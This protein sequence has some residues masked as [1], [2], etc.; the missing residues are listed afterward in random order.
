M[1]EAST[2][3]MKGETDSCAE[4]RRLLCPPSIMGRSSRQK[5]TRETGL[6]QY[7]SQMGFRNTCR[8]SCPMTVGH[9]LLTCTGDIL[10]ITCQVTKQVSK[11]N[12]TDVIPSIFN[13]HRGVKPEIHSSRKIHTYAETKQPSCAHSGS[14]RNKTGNL[15]I[16]QDDQNENIPKLLGCRKSNPK[17][18]V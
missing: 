11:S 5:I 9:A 16:L 13:N 15:K 17:K 10:Q 6:D 12:K 4:Q 7:S 8:T 2:D 14:R 3:R 18:E 1:C